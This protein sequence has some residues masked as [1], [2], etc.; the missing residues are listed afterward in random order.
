MCPC[1]N[2]AG[3]QTVS[4]GIV[5]WPLMYKF[6]EEIGEILTPKPSSVKKVYQNGN[7]SYIL[8]P[9]GIPIV[10]RLFE[11]TLLYDFKSSS[12]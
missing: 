1:I 10:S 11:D 2:L 3:K 6:L 7:S 8:S 9:K 12:L 5:C 4:D